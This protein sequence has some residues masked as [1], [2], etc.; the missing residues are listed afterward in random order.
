MEKT[1]KGRKLKGVVMS[2]KM[3]KTVVV[4]VS[5][6]KKHPK[7]HKYF[8]Q[9]SRFKAHDEDNQYKKGDE[10]VIQECRP[11]SKDKRWQVVGLIKDEKAKK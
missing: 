7:Y 8:K 5:K 1:L 6:D 10:V 9:N 2:D 11:L 4:Q 3:E